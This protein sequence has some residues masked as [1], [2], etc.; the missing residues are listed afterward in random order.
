MH[1]SPSG[2]PVRGIYQVRILEW[3]AT[4]FSR[5]SSWHRDRTCVSCIGR[6]ILYHWAT[7]EAHIFDTVGQIQSNH[8]DIFEREHI[9]PMG[10]IFFNL[11]IRKFDNTISKCRDIY[12]K[13]TTKLEIDV[14][15]LVQS[16]PSIFCSLLFSFRMFY[17]Q[18]Y[19]LSLRS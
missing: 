13:F 2:P 7:R 17:Y 18:S 9:F 8:Q 15:C 16:L 12:R 6:W 1:C 10:K 4:A 19:Y 11:E 3:T 5:G 14:W